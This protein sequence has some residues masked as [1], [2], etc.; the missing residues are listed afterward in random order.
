M[1]KGDKEMLVKVTRIID[2]DK[3]IDGLIRL[4]KEWQ[5]AANGKLLAEVQG[6]IGFLLVDLIAAIGLFPEEAELILGDETYIDA[7]QLMLPV[8]E[9][10]NK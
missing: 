3:A 9:K 1:P 2:R 8:F 7:S 10:V 6:S 5:E 4:R